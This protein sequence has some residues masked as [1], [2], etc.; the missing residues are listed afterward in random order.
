MKRSIAPSTIE[1]EVFA[2]PSKSIMQRMTAA[3]LLAE[4]KTTEIRNASF[5]SDCLASLDVAQKLGARI[6]RYK[7]RVVIK[8]GLSPS[9]K[10]LSFGES[11]LGIR[12]FAPIASLW[13][14]ELTLDGE[15][16]LRSR[17]M[18]MFVA[19]F[20]DVGVKCTTH[21]GHIPIT[22]HGPLRGGRTKVDASISSQF[23]TGLLMALPR[24]SGDSELH[25]E[26]MTSQPYID[27]TLKVLESCGIHV[28]QNNYTR[29]DIQGNQTYEPKEYTVE[30]DWSGA[31]FLCV[32]AAVGGKVALKGLDIRSPQPDK[33]IL[34]VLKDCGA[35]VHISPDIVVVQKSE[36]KPFDTDVTDCPDLMPPLASLACSC[37]GTSR[38]RGVD[39]LRYK[40]SDRSAVLQQELSRMGIV[41][42]IT[43]GNIEIQGGSVRGGMAQSHGDHRI[44]MAISVLAINAKQPI[45][46]EGTECVNKSY[47]AFFQD[48]ASIGGKIDE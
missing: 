13:P 21:N 23:L 30:G 15:G 36:L 6:T 1:G 12:M 48:L 11:G 35:I 47:P 31:A 17:P 38:I 10:K 26:N 19:P 39:R 22:I 8:G 14:G 29:F 4:G 37:Q 24:A 43:G 46:I 5:S 16:S 3:A 33:K 18:N 7:N 32:A 42:Q 40:E 41:S 44:V 45:T 9:E 34:D 28:R 27:L 20:R 2:P 25:V